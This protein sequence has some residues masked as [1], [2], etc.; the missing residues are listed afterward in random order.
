MALLDKSG[1]HGVAEM[2]QT[3]FLTDMGQILGKPRPGVPKPLIDEGKET[4]A[5]A[6]SI[7]PYRAGTP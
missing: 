2:Q 5:Y 4:P 1:P 7:A 6:R 3:A